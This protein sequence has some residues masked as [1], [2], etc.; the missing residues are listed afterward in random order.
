MKI[1]IIGYG[2]MGKEI[3]AIALERGHTISN[4]FS[5][6]SPFNQQSK[7]DADVAIEF[8]TPKL[9]IK[10]IKLCLDQKIPVVVGTT[11]WLEQLNE[12]EEEVSI[13]KGSLL[14]A[15]N[16]SLG[17]HLFWRL[18]KQLSELMNQNKSYKASITE[19]HHTEK[20]DQ[21]S[22]TAI[23]TADILINKQ[24]DY[25]SWMLSGGQILGNSTLPITSKRIANVP[26][27]HEV[28]YKSDIDQISLIHEA[29]N[30][31]GFALGAVIASE[32]LLDKKGTFTMSDII[33]FT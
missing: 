11:G 6:N 18:T 9:A 12:I 21:P 14:Y 15:S 2:K 10:H 8:S 32:W 24:D 29:K 20:Q 23:T 26:G 22:G 16:F 27:T 3:E 30:R 25:K 31:K 33:N 7:I 17:V 4:I 1:A 28:T 13:K 19:T 5:S